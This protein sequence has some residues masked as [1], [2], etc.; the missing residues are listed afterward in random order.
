MTNKN[1]KIKKI[2]D[3][4][5]VDRVIKNKN[6]F[7]EIVD[8]YQKKIWRYV[9]YLTNNKEESE[10]IVQE[11]FIKA[12]INLKSFNKNLKFSSWIFRIAHNEAVNFLKK[13]KV[14][15]SFNE[16]I[17]E[18]KDEREID[19]EFFKKELKRQIKN[20][21]ENL[22]VIYKEIVELYYFEELSYEEISDILKV[23]SGTVAIRL[24]RAKKILKKLC[25]KQKI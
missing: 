22:P 23:P 24:S 16:K 12:Y 17:F 8:R 1:E 9:F 14:N 18:V 10:D 21:L 6:F 2:T 15:L 11:I 19:E 25:Q 5:L 7:E 3:E 13:N 20:C 4:E